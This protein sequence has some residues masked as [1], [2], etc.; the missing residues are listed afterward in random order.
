MLPVAVI[1][2][3]VP[4]LPTLALPL[5]LNVPNTLAP[6]VVTTNTF[7][8]PPTLVLTLPLDTGI[9]TLL[10]PFKIVLVDGGA[11]HVNPPEPFV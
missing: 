5:E 1:A 11:T 6:V 4:K 2:P 3:L 8:T 7:A 10:V 9:L